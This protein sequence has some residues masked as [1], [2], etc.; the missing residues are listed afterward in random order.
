MLVL[1]PLPYFWLAV[2]IHLMNVIES[3]RTS[4]SLIIERIQ[5]S[6]LSARVPF[7]RHGTSGG[8]KRTPP[9]GYPIFTDD[10]K[11]FITWLRSYYCMTGSLLL[12]EEVKIELHAQC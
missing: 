8:K 12:E 9:G 7:A 10:D 1:V 5:V 4:W 11:V 2:S 3:L 6:G